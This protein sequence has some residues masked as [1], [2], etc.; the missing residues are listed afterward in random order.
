[1]DKVTFAYLKL[2][3]KLANALAC[4]LACGV[5]YGMMLTAYLV[6]EISYHQFRNIY[7]PKGSQ[8]IVVALKLSKRMC[9]YNS[10]AG[11]LA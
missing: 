9:S 1:M 6:T 5:G 4:I 3:I 2:T 10:Y 7:D 8:F 11:K